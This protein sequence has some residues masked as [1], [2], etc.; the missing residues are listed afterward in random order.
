M[1]SYNCGI[2][3]QQL[4][5]KVNLDSLDEQ[6]KSKG[7]PGVTESTNKGLHRKNS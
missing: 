5:E 3:S 2:A 6:G 4:F 1:S 7:A